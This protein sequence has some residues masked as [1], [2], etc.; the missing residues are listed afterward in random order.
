MRRYPLDDTSQPLRPPTRTT[1][2]F[3]YMP[4][5]S[6]AWVSAALVQSSNKAGVYLNFRRGPVPDRLYESFL[7]ARGTIEASIGDELRWDSNDKGN[8][9]AIWRTFGGQMLKEQREAVLA[10]L[11]DYVNRFVN[12]FRPRI[13]SLLREQELVA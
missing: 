11:G 12:T 3:Y 6:E 5:G 7:S 13:T 9:V 1:N 8:V 10:W 2:Q 4:Q